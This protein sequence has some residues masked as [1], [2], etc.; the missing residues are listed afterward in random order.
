MPKFLEIL[1]QSEFREFVLQVYPE[2]HILDRMYNDIDELHTGD[3][4]FYVEA[5]VLSEIRHERRES[6]PLAANLLEI[7]ERRQND[8]VATLHQA[9]GSEQLQH[10]SFRPERRNKT[11]LRS[12]FI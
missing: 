9:D 12:V 2:V 6:S 7:I 3:H 10:E 11:S 4:E 8:L 1:V 5:V